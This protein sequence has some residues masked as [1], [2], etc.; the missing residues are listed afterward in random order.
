MKIYQWIV[1]FIPCAT[2]CFGASKAPSVLEEYNLALGDFQKKK[3][4]GVIEHSKTMIKDHPAS[5][6]LSEVTYLAGVAYFQKKDY[7][8][9]D[10]YFSQFL[11]K[12]ATPKYFEEALEYRFRIAEK[13][14]EGAGLHV[15]GWEKMP[16][17]LSAWDMAYDIYDKVITTLPRHE[18]AAGA[19]KNKGRMLTAD[20]KY[21]EA[22][23]CYQMLIRRFP[24]HPSSPEAY[25][26]IA[27]LYL[28]ESQEDYPGKD[29]LEQAR[30]N[31][32]KFRYDFPRENRLV[33]A[34]A[35]LVEMQ[36]R[37]A[38]DLWESAEYY[39]RKKKARPA[40][41]YLD[42]IAERYPQSRYASSAIVQLAKIKKEHPELDMPID[43]IIST[44]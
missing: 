29:F 42:S 10:Y 18:I 3:W 15:F 23:D 6:F 24:K 9:A 28:L 1:L 39:L 12:Y 30:L 20:G 8:M 13:F 22:I 33:E 14:E 35:I 32:K 26:S 40:I 19:L 41:M 31:L 43:K 2:L 11:D 17:W 44:N 34:E 7:E 27:K 4:S 21:K 38:K 5:P 37:Y 36:D 16:Q 25:L